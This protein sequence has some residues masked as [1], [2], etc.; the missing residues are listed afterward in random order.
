MAQ[1]EEVYLSFNWMSGTLSSR[2]G[3]LTNLAQFYVDGNDLS[4][5]LPSELG[6]LSRLD[7]LGKCLRRPF[8]A[9]HFSSTHMSLC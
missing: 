5:T 9:H 6:L 7:N 1:L 8:S 2:I 4:G 3:V